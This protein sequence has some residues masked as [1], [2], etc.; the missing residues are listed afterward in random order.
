MLARS[1]VSVLRKHDYILPLNHYPIPPHQ[2]QAYAEWNAQSYPLTEAM[3]QEVLSLPMGPTLSEGEA[4]QV[5]AA[6]NGFNAA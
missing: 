4:L 6:V 5:A 1:D 2:Q 3:H